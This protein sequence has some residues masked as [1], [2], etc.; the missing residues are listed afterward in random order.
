MDPHTV[1]STVV[2]TIT[3]LRSQ[4]IL[5]DPEDEQA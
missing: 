5:Q 2:H 4:R 1:T 3:G